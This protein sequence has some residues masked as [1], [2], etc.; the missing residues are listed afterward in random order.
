MRKIVMLYFLFIIFL[1]GC[2]EKPDMKSNLAD[3]K[4]RN[5][6]L[7]DSLLGKWGGPGESTPVFEIRK[8]SIYYLERSVAYPYKIIDRDFIIYFPDHSATLRGIRVDHDTIFF[9]DDQGL[10]TIGIRF[11]K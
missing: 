11:K 7:S 6:S 9:S 8:D 4:D 10:T 3:M 5:S 1:I 2:K